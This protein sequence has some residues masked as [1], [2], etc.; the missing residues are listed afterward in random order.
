MTVNQCISVEINL[1]D[2]RT[3]GWTYRRDNCAGNVYCRAQGIRRG[4]GMTS[5]WATKQNVGAL[6]AMKLL[7]V[8]VAHSSD[9]TSVMGVERRGGHVREDERINREYGRNA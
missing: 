7:R 4:V 5:V 3:A 8:G 9:E 1:D 6:G 2:V